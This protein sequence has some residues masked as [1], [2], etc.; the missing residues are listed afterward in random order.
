MKLST[1][2]FEDPTLRWFLHKTHNEPLLLLNQKN[3]VLY[4]NIDIKMHLINII[5]FL[6]KKNI[7]K[8][9]FLKIKI[10]ASKYIRKYSL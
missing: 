8:L 7:D 2:S 5:K 4:P 10:L 3:N 6:L 9:L 1:E